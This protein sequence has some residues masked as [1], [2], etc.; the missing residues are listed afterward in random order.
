MKM[1]LYVNNGF[2]QSAKFDWLDL[3][4]ANLCITS[5]RFGD[6]DGDG[7]TDVFRVSYLRSF[8][9]EI[10]NPNYVPQTRYD[11]CAGGYDVGYYD[12]DFDTEDEYVDYCTGYESDGASCDTTLNVVHRIYQFKYSSGGT[13]NWITMGDTSGLLSP[14]VGLSQLRFGF[15]DD[16]NITDIF[17][18]DEDGR[19]KYSSA[20]TGPWTN[21]AI[22]ANV[23][24][25]RLVILMVMG[26]LISL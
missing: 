2:C 12:C 24:D 13:S 23:N 10:P 3:A 21:L 26:K 20:G 17:V 14:L 8:T 4:T 18:V 7:K 16:D 22:G 11:P 6:F 9:E 5:L 19:W 15:F 25:M 1:I